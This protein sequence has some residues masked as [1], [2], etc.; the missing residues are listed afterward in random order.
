MSSSVEPHT[1]LLIV[2]RRVAL[3]PGVMLV[4]VVE[5]DASFVILASIFAH[6]LTDTVGARWI[7]RRLSVGAEAA[8]D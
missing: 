2:Q 1:P 3:V 7:E 8:A 4:M 6:G 5:G